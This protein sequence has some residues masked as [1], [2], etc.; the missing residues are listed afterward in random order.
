M[1][2]NQLT[3]DPVPRESSPPRLESSSDL[4]TAASPAQ[5]ETPIIRGAHGHFVKGCSANPAGQP[6]RT[7]E[8]KQALAEIRA[9]APEVPRYMKAMLKNPRTPAMAK[10][11]LMEI[12][13]ERTY[14]KPEESVTVKASPL[15]LEASEA[16]IEA[17]IRT[18]RLEG[19][20]D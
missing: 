17:L 20:S 16:R 9:L 8:Q 1:P 13:L 7:E 3:L 12:I 4:L 6:K 11:R 19:D 2:D 10:I 18:I 14:G 5:E 15:S